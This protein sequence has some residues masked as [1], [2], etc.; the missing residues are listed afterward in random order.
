MCRNELEFSLGEI[1]FDSKGMFL[2]V[3][4]NLLTVC[5]KLAS[6]PTAGKMSE[7]YL[8]KI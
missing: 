7:K 1:N 3:A 5:A 6:I 4:I 8:L 2:F